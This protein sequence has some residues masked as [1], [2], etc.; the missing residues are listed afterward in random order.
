MYFH[1]HDPDKFVHHVDH[2]CYTLKWGRNK[3]FKVCKL[4]KEKDFASTERVYQTCPESQKRVVCG[5]RARTN[6]S[7]E[8][9]H[10]EIP[11]KYPEPTSSKPAPLSKETNKG[12]PSKKFYKDGDVIDTQDD[13]FF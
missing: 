3:Y 4:L 9:P 5:F 2:I 11:S 8:N 13:T 1:S 6:L 12:A 7:D 10:L